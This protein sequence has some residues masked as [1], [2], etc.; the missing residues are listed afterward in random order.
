MFGIEEILR[1]Y[2]MDLL[3]N[4]ECLNDSS[5]VDVVHY[6]FVFV[7]SDNKSSLLHFVVFL[8]FVDSIELANIFSVYFNTIYLYENSRNT[9]D[10]KFN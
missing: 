6:V 9:N 1:P 2:C 3:D 8:L 10:N 5:R 4:V 7:V